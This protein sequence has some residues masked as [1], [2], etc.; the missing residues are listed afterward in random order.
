MDGA[1]NVYLLITDWVWLKVASCKTCEKEM[2]PMFSFDAAD[3]LSRV[4]W[5]V[6]GF[7]LVLSVAIFET[8]KAH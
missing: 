1:T 6:R 2:D 8:D 5:S 3:T 4:F 7:L